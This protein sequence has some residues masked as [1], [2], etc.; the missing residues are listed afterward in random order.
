MNDIF[1]APV[2]G[3]D[4]GAS[5]TKISY[6]PPRTDGAYKEPSRIVLIQ[7]QALVPSLVVHRNSDRKPWL[8][9]WEAAEYHPSVG[10][11]VFNN[12]KARLFS[13]TLD[14]DVAGHLGAAGEFFKW[15]R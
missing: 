14:A 9:G 13:Q 6:R 7:N 15:L 12:W 1:S 10:D 3:I 5:F 11:R 8:C 2:L 4:L